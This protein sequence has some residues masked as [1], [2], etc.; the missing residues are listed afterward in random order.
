MAKK[1]RF[2]LKLAEGAEVRTLEELREHFDLQAILE[3]YKSGKLLTWLEDRYLEGEAEAVQA[4]DESAADFQRR[5]CEMFQVEYTGAGVDME[6]IERRQERLKRLRTVTDDAECIQN[7]DSVAFDQE[8]LADL[9]DEGATKIYLCGD[10]FTVPASRKGITYVGIKN[11]AVHISGKVPEKAEELESTFHGCMVDNLLRTLAEDTTKV[12]EKTYDCKELP[13][14]AVFRDGLTLANYQLCTESMGDKPFDKWY[15]YEFSSGKEIELPEELEKAL[16]ECKRS[17]PMGK[18]MSSVF[19][20]H[21]D[22]ILCRNWDKN[23]FFIL[24]IHSGTLERFNEFRQY[25][26][27]NADYITLTVGL[28]DDIQIIYRHSPEQHKALRF[29]KGHVYWGKKMVFQADYIRSFCFDTAVLSAQKMFFKAEILYGKNTQNWKSWL[30]CFDICTGSFNL[31]AELPLKE[32]SS[33]THHKINVICAN[34]S[35][36]Y[37]Y[38]RDDYSTDDFEKIWKVDLHDSSVEDLF[39]YRKGNVDFDNRFYKVPCI[40]SS[41]YLVWLDP[42][43]EKVKQALDHGKALDEV[44]SPGFLNFNYVE[45]KKVTL[46]LGTK[47]ENLRE[48]TKVQYDFSGA[49]SQRKKYDVSNLFAVELSTG[50]IKTLPIYLLSHGKPGY[51]HP[52]FQIYR[53]MLYCCHWNEQKKTFFDGVGYKFNLAAESLEA[54][55]FKF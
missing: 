37:L 17:R 21:E 9:L 8:E 27:F 30:V 43:I 20:I 4:L 24:N 26:D 5:L 29:D 44:A 50:K 31:V 32:I 40:Y 14:E 2:P 38:E 15:R 12:E 13:L 42:D 35:F 51:P 3:Y 39:H 49:E 45:P 11:P 28:A 10:K 33:S 25:I 34:D 47:L 48:E 55:E 18:E 22:E 41:E 23:Q 52:C 6:E 7:I 46:A 19:T 36:V 16:T 54:I 1:I 53:S